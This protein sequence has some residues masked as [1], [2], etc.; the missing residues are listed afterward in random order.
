MKTSRT[1]IVLIIFFAINV[2]KADNF[3]GL[4]GDITIQDPEHESINHDSV[5]G[6]LDLYIAHTFTN[7]LSTLIEYVYDNRG[8][9]NEGHAE[10]FS[11]KYSYNPKFNIAMGRFHTPLGNLNRTQHHGTLLQ[12]TVN[13]PFFLDFHSDTII[14]PLH[15]VGFMA[16]GLFRKNQINIGYETS[17][18]SSQSITLETHHQDV[19]VNIDPNNDLSGSINPGLSARMHLYPDNRQWLYGFFLLNHETENI[20]PAAMNLFEQ[21]IAGIDIQ[22]NFDKWKLATEY[23]HINNSDLKTDKVYSSNAAFMEG[24]YSLNDNIRLVYRFETI[25]LNTNDTY[26]S[27]FSMTDQNR[28]VAAIRFDIN[29]N[30]ALKL[31]LESIDYKMQLPDDTRSIYVQ[32]S[33][34]IN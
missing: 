21:T 15:V 6:T 30:H 2:A 23:F 20:A 10:R 12:D 22:Y 4:F 27:I 19:Y 13:R 34:L 18:H 11:V 17:L 33:F 7:K 29:E 25:N 26:Y 1:I 32:W 24:T 5:S 28:H 3:I 8:L 14:L 9:H 31:Q 16:D